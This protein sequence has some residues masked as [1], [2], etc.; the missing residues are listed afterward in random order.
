MP[1][2]ILGRGGAS[3]SRHQNDAVNL[4]AGWHS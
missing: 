2:V 3:H 4:P 1:L